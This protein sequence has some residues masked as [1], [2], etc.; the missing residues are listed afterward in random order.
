MMNANYILKQEELLDIKSY[1]RS[2]PPPPEKC[3][4]VTYLVDELLPQVQQ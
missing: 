4:V 1:T 2:P 3:A